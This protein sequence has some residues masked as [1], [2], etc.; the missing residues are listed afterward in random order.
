MKTLF[1]EAKYKEKISLGKEII[2]LLPFK[3]ALV[4]SIQ[5]IDQLGI[6]K[7]EINK[8]AIIAGQILGCNVKNAE[9]I[10]N[11]Q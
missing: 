2:K 4:S 5:F 8:K 11:K 3:I 6:I 1:I 10:K 9:K 7:K